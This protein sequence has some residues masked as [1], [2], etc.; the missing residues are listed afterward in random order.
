MQY[1]RLGA[2]ATNIYTHKPG[3]QK[4]KV[5]IPEYK[6]TDLTLRAPLL[7]LHLLNCLY[8]TTHFQIPL[9]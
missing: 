2:L 6:D 5:S 4:S 8:L 3:V 9:Y 1:H 7:C